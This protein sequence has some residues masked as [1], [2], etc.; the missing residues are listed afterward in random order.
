MVLISHQ[1]FEIEGGVIKEIVPCL[2]AEKGFR[3]DVGFFA[4]GF[5]LEDG[6]FRQFQD[7]VQPPQDGEGG[8]TISSLCIRPKA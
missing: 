7:A 8:Y 3:V 5:F 6:C 4:F 1:L 2:P